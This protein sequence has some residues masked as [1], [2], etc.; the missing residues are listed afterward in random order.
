MRAAVIRTISYPLIAGGLG[1]VIAIA[2]TYGVPYWPLFPVL[3]GLGLYAVACLERRQPYEPL[4]RHD[5]GDLRTDIFHALVNVG[6]QL[7]AVE[8]LFALRE[9]FAH[10]ALWPHAWPMV[11][12]ILLA[13]TVI[14]LGL[15]LMHRWS[16][17]APWLWALHAP[18]HS[19]ERLYWLNGERRHPLHALLMAGPGL[20]AVA[21]A[22]APPVVVAAW[23]AFLTIHLAFQHA[24]LD[25][26][27][28]PLNRW[29]GVAAVHRWHHK[30]EY[31]DAQV[32]F[33]EFWMI[34]DRLFGTFHDS[35][36]ALRAGDVGL[37]D[38]DYPQTYLAQ[39]R[40]PF[41]RAAVK[42][43]VPSDRFTR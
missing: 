37:R 25:Y 7:L 29:I 24:N 26:T 38:R 6:L 41:G 1:A 3:V 2:T 34:W 11:L 28:G 10:D 39:L 30:R 33:G 8:A 15:Y 32:N 12:Q 9:R 22:G 31:E 35:P 18:H 17:R 42:G 19:P 27:L 13:G 21:L 16:H 36:G 14:D 43:D 5:H 40:A 4:W 23:L 20:L